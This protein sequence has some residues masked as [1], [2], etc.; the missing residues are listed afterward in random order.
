M[1][2]NQ[3]TVSG[4]VT[5]KTA[6]AAQGAKQVRSEIE[7]LAKSGIAGFEA[8]QQ[9]VID[10]TKRLGELRNELLRTTDPARQ[11]QLNAELTRTQ[12]QFKAARTEMRGMSLESRETNEKVQML[13]ATLGVRVPE[14]MARILSRMPALT[15]AMEAAFSITIVGA[16]AAA[17]IAI[18]PKIREL[19]QEVGGVTESTKQLFQWA[20]GGSNKALVSFGTL[21]EGQKLIAETNRGLIGTEIALAKARSITGQLTLTNLALIAFPL[22]TV[23]GL[24]KTW[25]ERSDAIAKL[26][27]QQTDLFVRLGEQTDQ[28]TKLQE[29][30]NK[31]AGKEA[32]DALEK[33]RLALLEV[34]EAREADWNSLQKATQDRVKAEE[35]ADKVIEETRHQM[36]M[37]QIRDEQ[38][39]LHETDERQKRAWEMQKAEIE[40]A[41]KAADEQR[42]I[43]DQLSQSIESFIERT[44]LHARS[45][46]DV[47]HQFLMQLL[48]SFVKW[49]S[50][51]VA[52]AVLGMRQVS[53]GQATGGGGILGQI[54]GG[55]FGVGGG[56]GGMAAAG[57]GEAAA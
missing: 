1:G 51:M 16:F 34:A 55:I 27:K 49:V 50:Q 35:E 21:A 42:H 52:R 45:L 57:F 24:Y 20:V 29:Q 28:L 33:Q 43:Y 10:L 53:T 39:I 54:L 44:F 26:T 9:K 37:D 7:S 5:L 38:A 3:F 19:A 48:G 56:G 40:G 6:Q 22:T 32:A 36:A 14:G 11:A 2:G 15:A 23:V 13:A 4:E 31:V 25:T 17:I 41:R 12:A 8:T 46:A 30:H 47:W 18:V